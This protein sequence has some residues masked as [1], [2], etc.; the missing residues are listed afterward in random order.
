VIAARNASGVRVR[1][2]FSGASNCQATIVV[3]HPGAHEFFV[4]VFNS[5]VENRVEKAPL[6]FEIAGQYGAY[7]SLH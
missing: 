5:F 2:N 4:K 7:S 6:T 3:K 1:E